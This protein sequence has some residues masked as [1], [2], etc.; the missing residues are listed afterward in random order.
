MRQ[1]R[2]LTGILAGIAVLV[3]L[4]VGLY[5]ARRGTLEYGPE[6]NPAGVTR[7]FIVAIKK[8]DF[9]RALAALADIENKP[10]AFAFRQTFQQ[11]Q[12]SEVAAT[13]VEVGAATVQGEQA[14]VQ[15]SMLRGGGGLFNEAYRDQQ[16][17]ELVLQ[18]G[19]W[20]IKAMPYPFW[21]F[22]WTEPAKATPAP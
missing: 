21:N 20:K 10:D 3:I 11:F 13:G 8:G 2:F 19:V 7:N 16:S 4:T 5:F 17:A 1:D 18:G 6:D 14:Y 15:V 12:A 9:D 22:S